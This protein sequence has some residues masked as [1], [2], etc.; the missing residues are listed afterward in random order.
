MQKKILSIIVALIIFLVSAF[1]A[2]F[3][4]EYFRK[5]VRYFYQYSTDGNITFMGKNFHFFASGEFVLSFGLFC[6]LVHYVFK[7]FPI[8][9]KIVSGLLVS[10]L[11][12]LSTF[13]ISYLDSNGRIMAC[14]ACD[15]GKLSIH[16]NAIDYDFIFITSLVISIFPFLI[17]FIRAFAA[18]K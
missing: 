4:D 8:K 14:T 13:V 7:E 15:N 12:V 6:L 3:Y 2:A 11:F 18:K 10:L 1:I 9:K 16:Y 5:L 17:K